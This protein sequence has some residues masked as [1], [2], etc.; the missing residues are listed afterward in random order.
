MLDQKRT[1]PLRRL[2]PL[3][4][5]A[6]DA[7]VTFAQGFSLTDFLLSKGGRAKFLEFVKQGD[8]DS[9]ARSVKAHYGYASLDDLE[10]AWLLHARKTPRSPAKVVG[11]PSSWSSL[12]SNDKKPT[13]KLP[14]APA[15]EHA[16]VV[17]KGG[18]LNFWRKTITYQPVTRALSEQFGSVTSYEQTIALLA[19]GY[20][21]EQVKAYDTRGRVVEHKTLPG[22]LKGETVVL[23]SADGKRVDPFYL[24]LVKEGTLVF[25]LPVSS[26]PRPPRP[27]TAP[28]PLVPA[29]TEGPARR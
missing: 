1:L 28:P 19:T 23:V 3:R 12:S 5:Y 27:V 25:V 26:P 14:D 4:E 8:R 10:Q 17:L 21:V 22:L 24:R 13:S 9:W 20:A 18:R 29:F 2:L 16:L 7:M 15:P 6:P 11:G